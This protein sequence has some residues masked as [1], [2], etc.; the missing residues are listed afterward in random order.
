MDTLDA[1]PLLALLRIFASTTAFRLAPENKHAFA[2]GCA[3]SI[4]ELNQTGFTGE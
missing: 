2:S 1:D 4:R 3:H